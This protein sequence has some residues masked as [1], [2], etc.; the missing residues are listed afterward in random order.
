MLPLSQRTVRIDRTHVT[1]IWTRS[2]P[3]SKKPSTIGEHLR[4]RRFLLGL[5]QSQAAQQL[6]VSKRTLGLWERD[7]VCPSWKLQTRVVTFLGYD[8]FTDPALGMPGG[9]KP[10][11]VAFSS[12]CGAPQTFGQLLFRHRIQFKKTRQEFAKE[13]GI[14][15][16]TLRGWEIGLHRP[17]GNQE[18]RIKLVLDV[19]DT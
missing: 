17:S 10:D 12:I 14:S 18:N 4:K 19:H 7:K 6:G 1:P 5:R 8:P 9:N 3:V 11:G 15:V 16:K 2:Y 13:L